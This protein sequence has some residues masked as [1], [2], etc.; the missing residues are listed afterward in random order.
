MKLCLP[1][2]YDK[3]SEQILWEWYCNISVE[4]DV[5]FLDKRQ[6]SYLSEY[7]IEAG[8][9][10]KRKSSFFRHHYAKPFSAALSFL[11]SIPKK[12]PVILD[13]GCGTGTQ[14]LAFALLGAK[15]IAL[16]MDTQALEIL[17]KRKHF[18]EEKTGRI[19][20]IQ[21]GNSNVFAFDFSSIA[22]IDGL[23]SLFA[24]NMMQPSRK[25]LSLIMPYMATVGRIAILD[26]NCS[27]FASRFFP[28]RRRNVLSPMEL[29]EEIEK[30]CFETVE[31]YGGVVFPPALWFIFPYSALTKLDNWFSNKSWVFPVSHQILA[32]HR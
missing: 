26:G 1:N 28:W 16:D 9:L 6:Q 13:L 3:L 10:R 30:Y 7:Y 22:P 31:H 12:R 21:T 29:K 18:Y 8:L 20:D 15:V 25:L 32:Q 14:S 5:G 2:T 17:H 27:S 11:L 24:F 4:I 23:Y 19:L